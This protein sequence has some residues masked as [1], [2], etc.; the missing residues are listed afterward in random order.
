VD[1][2]K[3]FILDPTL[4]IGAKA[5]YIALKSHCKA[6]DDTAFPS[7]AYLASCLNI[8]RDTVHKYVAELRELGWVDTEQQGEDGKFTHTLY[9]VNDRSG[10]NPL[11]KKP[12][13]EK[14]DTKFPQREEE[15]PEAKKN[16]AP[17]AAVAFDVCLPTFGDIEQMHEEP[18]QEKKVPSFTTKFI[19][20]WCEA[21]LFVRGEKYLV[22]EGKDHAAAKRLS[23]MGMPI[24]DL[25]SLARRAWASSGPKFWRCEKALTISYFV[26]SF[27]E[28]RAELS[29][30]PTPTN[31]THSKNPS[32]H[33][34][35]RFIAGAGTGPTTSEIIKRNKERSAAECAAREAAER[36]SS[37]AGPVAGQVAPATEHASSDF[38]SL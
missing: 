20:A 37:P 30:K 6:G 35:N 19:T 28:I 23:S 22:C 11:R 9:T 13:A 32:E 36:L 27:N 16:S 29:A 38:G 26:S 12:V 4:S 25:I 31:A 5:I 2:R 7:S 24:A 33:P 14:A 21:F 8:S 10:K 3:D 18:Q 34:R 15:S 1:V 17:S